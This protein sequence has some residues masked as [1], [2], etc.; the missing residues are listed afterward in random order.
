MAKRNGGIIGPS[1]VPTGQYGGVAP[2][3]WRLR[4]AFNYIKA[5]LWPA[6]GNYPVGNSL[7][8]NSGSSDYLNRTFSAS[9]RRTWTYSTWFKKSSNASSINLFSSYTDGNNRQQLTLDSNDIFWFFLLQGGAFASQIKTTQV[10]R[11]PSAWYHLILAVDSTQ[12]TAS[13]RIKIYL[14]GS[15][16]TTFS[17]SDYMAQNNDGIINNNQVHYVGSAAPVSDYF[18]GYM[19]ETFFIDGQQLTP[20]SFGQTDSTTGIWTP[21]PYTGTYGTNGFYLK[22]ANSASLGTDSSGNAN[23][24]TVNNLTSVDQSTGTPTNNF[25]TLNPL[26]KVSSSTLTEGNLKETKSNKGGVVSTLAVNKGKWYCE[27]KIDTL[28]VDPQIGIYA[29]DAGTVGYQ[30]TYLGVDAFS[31]GYLVNNAYVL[32]YNAVTAN[33]YGSAFS[34]G[35]I[36]IIALDMDNKKMWFGK[37]GTWFS[38]GNPATGANPVQSI[39]AFPPDVTN[40]FQAFATGSNSASE[41]AVYSFNFGNPPYSANS[42]TDGAGYGNFSYAVPSGYYALCT[43]N[44]A[45]YG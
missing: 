15:Q 25:A 7:R 30:T 42:Y 34:N 37:N 1:N 36:M 41:N 19:A 24:F 9:N 21:L 23:T 14:N 38:S 13:N 5:G 3:V 29:V 17:T 39:S 35:D 31:M 10:F 16:I 44:L 6:V 45:T 12:A 22:F 18:N 8:F 43:K 33:Y 27:V 28:G 32:G 20:S 26:S 11:D 4:D 2:G 40:N